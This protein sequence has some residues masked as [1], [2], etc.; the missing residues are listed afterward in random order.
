MN[1][2]T[3][4]VYWDQ[5]AGDNLACNPDNL[6]PGYEVACF[7]VTRIYAS[8]Y[9]LQ[10]LALWYRAQQQMGTVG[11]LKHHRRKSTMSNSVSFA[12]PGASNENV[13][14]RFRHRFEKLASLGF[15]IK[16]SING[17]VTLAALG[18]SLFLGRP[19]AYSNQDIRGQLADVFCELDMFS[20]PA[21]IRN[22]SH[23]I[24]R[25]VASIVHF[26]PQRCTRD[27]C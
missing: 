17:G 15:G 5:F 18:V 7:F 27:Y 10:A 25:L 20:C 23:P 2:S 3:E 1:D 24:I 21:S 13:S 8:A 14:Q 19:V 11:R 6:A 12:V 4:D 16:V 22:T 9:I 26:P